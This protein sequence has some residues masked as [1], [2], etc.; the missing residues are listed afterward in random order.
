M[1]IGL[2]THISDTTQ[3]NSSS[4]KFISN[5]TQEFC[6][7][8]HSLIKWICKVYCRQLPGKQMLIKLATRRQGC[9]VSRGFL[10]QSNNGYKNTACNINVIMIVHT[11]GYFEIKNIS[12]FFLKYFFQLKWNNRGMYFIPEGCP[13]YSDS[14]I[15]EW[16]SCCWNFN[17]SFLPHLIN[18]SSKFEVILKYIL[19]SAPENIVYEI[20]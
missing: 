2:V 18:I 9:R 8:K 7:T 14:L 4:S 11:Y 17:L 15:T 19:T 5:N 1:E 3:P 12:T 6:A 16:Q 13:M 10:F 20:W